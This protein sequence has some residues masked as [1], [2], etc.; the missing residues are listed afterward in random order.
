MPLE[1]RA[2]ARRA[3]RSTRKTTQRLLIDVGVNIFRAG[4]VGVP[5][6][7]SVATPAEDDGDR[8]ARA[9]GQ[10]A[11]DVERRHGVVAVPPWRNQLWSR[12]QQQQLGAASADAHEAAAGG[13]HTQTAGADD[14]DTAAAASNC[15]R[16]DCPATGG[17]GNDDHVAAAAGGNDAVAAA[18]DTGLAT[19]ASTSGGGDGETGVRGDAND[20]VPTAIAP[21]GKSATVPECILSA[22]RE[23]VDDWHRRNN[24]PWHV[25]AAVA[26]AVCSS[27]PD[28]VAVQ[29]LACPT[30]KG[31]CKA[32][33]ARL[34]KFGPFG[35]K[36]G[37]GKFDLGRFV[38]THLRSVKHQ[39][40]WAAFFERT[41]RVL[42]RGEAVPSARPASPLPLTHLDVMR[43]THAKDFEI[44]A[45]AWVCRRCGHQGTFNACTTPG[46]LLSHL[47]SARCNR[48]QPVRVA[49]SRFAQFFVV[50][51][52]VK[53]R[54]VVELRFPR[55]AAVRI[56]QPDGTLRRASVLSTT[57]T[58]VT[59]A[60][61]LVIIGD[62]QPPQSVV[63]AGVD[64]VE[65]EPP[66]ACRGAWR[67]VL[68][69][70]NN[71]G[72]VDVHAVGEEMGDIVDGDIRIARNPAIHP[73]V[74]DGYGTVTAS[75][76]DTNNCGGQQVSP[77]GA[78]Q[79]W[80]CDH[81]RR[82]F[83]NDHFQARARAGVAR[84][85]ADSI[86]KISTAKLSTMNAP[87]LRAALRSTR[88]LYHEKL[89]TLR[90][91]AESKDNESHKKT[92]VN[93][94]AAGNLGFVTCY[95]YVDPYLYLSICLA[96]RRAL[97]FALA[98]A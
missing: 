10:L 26:C 91:W 3:L 35:S 90:R 95:L 34:Y 51:D 17:G 57:A 89:K 70:P 8:R 47:S 43:H 42:P 5:V 22:A 61:D 59:A 60:L 21:A 76:F 6:V 27:H 33:Q 94:M 18:S 63:Q 58:T 77:P 92:T 28:G 19:A 67:P 13:V 93:S 68:T 86:G 49:A 81:C 84:V 14:S 41:M 25:F 15:D 31:E 64:D 88:K 2:A 54:R 4:M 39:Q 74:V 69:L 48:L 78:P 83:K 36:L 44:T 97:A 75:F 40:N 12:Q 53:R 9:K 52:S 24:S 55:G 71:G 80:T 82:I 30:F 23:A 72:T 38:S 98:L 56:K 62:L 7:P 37:N 79:P 65:L 20:G 50:P 66:S 45:S 85:A 16:D 1:A 96:R 87:T 46:S 32:G 73:I 29:C 11:L